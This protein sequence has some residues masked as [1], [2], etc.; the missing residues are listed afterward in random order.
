MIVEETNRYAHKVKNKLNCN[1]TQRRKKIF[2]GFLILLGYH[3]LTSKRDFWAEADHFGG[4][5]VK[6]AVTKIFYLE[7]NTLLY[8]IF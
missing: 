4:T 7:F 2:I 5:I 3:T 8:H 6:K 1:F